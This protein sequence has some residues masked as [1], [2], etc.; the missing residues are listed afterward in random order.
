MNRTPEERISDSE[1]A[2]QLLRNQ[3]D[4]LQ[5]G[6]AEKKKPWYRQTPSLPSLL[7]LL[8]SITTA[9]YSAL[10]GHRQDVQKKQESLRGITAALIDLASE[11][12]AKLGSADAQKLSTQEREFIGGM[13]N[14]KRL[15][16][17][18][19]ADNLIRDIPDYV[20]S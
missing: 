9:V 8:L 19:A 6:A 10:Q 1:Y 4:E 11:Y 16:L 3:V 5:G 15:I 12:Q 13:L 7:A 20:S 18:E 14:N 2:I 17:A